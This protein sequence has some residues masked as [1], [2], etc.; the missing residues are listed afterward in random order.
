MNTPKPYNEKRN[1]N[2]IY[3]NFSQDIDESELIWHMDKEDRYVKVLN[4]S[5]WGFQ[6]DNE[7]PIKIEKGNVIEIPPYQYH[8]I[9]KGKGD[10]V[11]RI[12]EF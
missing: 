4:E 12:W 1:G 11:V 2:I 7:L 3:R 10:L 9:I 6:M 5:D 8:R